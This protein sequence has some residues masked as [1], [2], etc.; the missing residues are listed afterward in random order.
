[1]RW[2][3]SIPRRQW[4]WSAGPHR[5]GAV[6]QGGGHAGA[7][8]VVDMQPLPQSSPAF[9]APPSLIHAH[10]AA[11]S[12]TPTVVAS[13][14]ASVLMDLEPGTMDAFRTGPYGQIFC[15]DNFVFGQSDTGNNLA[16]HYTECRSP[17]S[18][19]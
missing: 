12:S 8:A 7:H 9:S 1:M 19:T 6:A 17:R 10:A 13:P 15:T 18:T 2:T 11:A 5:R 16:V 3:T 4:I 14:V